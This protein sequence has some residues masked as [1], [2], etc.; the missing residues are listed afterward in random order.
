MN[1]HEHLIQA[2]RHIAPHHP[3]TQD[4]AVGSRK[5]PRREF[6]RRAAACLRAS[7]LAFEK[8]RQLVLDRLERAELP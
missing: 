5:R 3:P 2:D 7:L 6:G 4:H 8:Y 1:E